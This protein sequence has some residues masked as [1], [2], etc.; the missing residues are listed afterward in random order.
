MSSPTL[1]VAAVL[2][3]MGPV[4]HAGSDRR[5]WTQVL[6]QAFQTGALSAQIILHDRPIR[7]PM[8]W[9]S[10]SDSGEAEHLWTMA[11][12]DGGKDRRTVERTYLVT[13]G[14]GLP[15]CWL[16][17][18][19]SYEVGPE[20]EL[21]CVMLN[22]GTAAAL[23]MRVVDDEGKGY[24]AI[25]SMGV[26]SQKNQIRRIIEPRAVRIVDGERVIDAERTKVIAGGVTSLPVLTR[27][28]WYRPKLAYRG[29]HLVLSVDGQV[30]VRVKAPGRRY[31][32]VQFMSPQR[33]YLDDLE[34]WGAV[35]K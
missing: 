21:Q 8:G 34:M 7:V 19:L 14:N 26:E 5:P 4:L 20:F 24:E 29:G 12:W 13:N 31:T 9:I 33:I 23:S 10:L 11:R 15:G 6:Y 2:L 17:K 3:S 32:T 35:D 22:H 28:Q 27:L 18:F 1:P 30:L 25:V 16:T